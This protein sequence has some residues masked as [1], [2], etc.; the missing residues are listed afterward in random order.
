MEESGCGRYHACNGWTLLTAMRADEYSFSPV[1]ESDSSLKDFFV[2]SIDGS[3]G[4]EI[5]TG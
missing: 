4:W 2:G 3:G 5:P 1:R